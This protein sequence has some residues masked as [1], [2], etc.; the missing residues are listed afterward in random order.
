MMVACGV[1]AAEPK[2]AYVSV[3][4]LHG[5]YPDESLLAMRVLL[6]SLKPLTH[7]F[8]VIVESTI[9]AD[10]ESLLLGAGATVKRVSSDWARFNIPEYESF[11]ILHAWA[12]TQ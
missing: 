5:E 1:A 11:L 4:D 3:L 8:I 10:T 6:S 2:H 12:L 7:P 9:P